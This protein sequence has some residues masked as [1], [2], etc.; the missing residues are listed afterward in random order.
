MLD[1]T[2]CLSETAS[3]CRRRQR[4]T[5][6]AFF[7]EAMGPLRL[8]LAELA[9]SLSPQDLAGVYRCL[10]QMPGSVVLPEEGQDQWQVHR[11]LA[12]RCAGLVKSEAVP[13]V[14][15]TSLLYSQMCL[16]AQVWV[17]EEQQGP[18]NPYRQELREGWDTLCRGWLKARERGD[19]VKGEDAVSK[20]Q[21]DVLSLL[22]DDA[23][24]RVEAVQGRSRL[25]PLAMELL[26]LLEELPLGGDR[27]QEAQGPVA[28]GPVKVHMALTRGGQ[29]GCCVRFLAESDYFRS[30][31]EEAA[32]EVAAQ[33]D[34]G[35]ALVVQAGGVKYELALERRA[36]LE[37]VRQRSWR[38][39]ALPF[40]SW[41]RLSRAEQRAMLADAVR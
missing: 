29:P 30:P 18:V 15:L 14:E 23:Q 21:T 19:A 36:E 16:Y 40:A 27:E 28:I 3:H 5:C 41:R 39:T 9:P 35:S 1:I 7:W 17:E 32:F 4:G 8:L 6:P 37:L 33:P 10:R 25:R 2:E 22:L 11:A 38:V 26:E 34:T 31:E 20:R 13:F 12:D 24:E